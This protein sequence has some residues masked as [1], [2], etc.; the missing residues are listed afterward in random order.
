LRVRTSRPFSTA[1]GHLDPE[2]DI[3]TPV[4]DLKKA[5]RWTERLPTEAA[6]ALVPPYVAHVVV[7]QH[8][9]LWRADATGMAGRCERVTQ[10]PFVDVD[11]QRLAGHRNELLR[12]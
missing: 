11:M 9:E 12:T 2:R 10:T 6:R 5:V 1:A 8:D 7:G 3:P 4:V